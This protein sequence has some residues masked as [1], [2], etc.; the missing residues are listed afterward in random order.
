MISFSVY[1]SSCFLSV[2]ANFDFLLQANLKNGLLKKV[3]FICCE[4]SKISPIFDPVAGEFHIW[5]MFFEDSD[6]A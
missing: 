5:W 2:I 3:Y 6:P 1:F 4:P